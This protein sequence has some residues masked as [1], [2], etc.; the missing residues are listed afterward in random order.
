MAQY[1]TKFLE[2]S[3]NSQPS[4]WTKRWNTNSSFPVVS[5]VGTIALRSTHS[6]SD[7]AV[8][9]WNAVPSKANVEI[10]A[11]IRTTAFDWY[12]NGLYVRG[13]G[14]AGSKT[15]YYFQMFENGSGG[16]GLVIEKWVGGSW[17][18]IAGVL[19]SWSPNT[20]YWAR[21]RVSGSNLYAKIW[22][23]GSPEPGSWTM[24]ASDG[25]IGGA[26]WVGVGAYEP[27][28]T[29]YFDEVAVATD[30]DTAV[31]TPHVYTL[32]VQDAVHGHTA[33]E[34]VTSIVAKPPEVEGMI[35]GGWGGQIL[36]GAPF[37]SGPVLTSTTT[38]LEVQDTVHGHTAEEPVTSIL[39]YLEPD[40]AVQGHTADNA[41]ITQHHFLE[42]DSSSQLHTALGSLVLTENFTLVVDDAFHEHKAETT[43]AVPGGNP[44]PDGT[45]HEHTID[46]ITL[47]QKHVLSVDSA[48]Q[49]HSADAVLLS[50]AHELVVEDAM[51]AHNAALIILSQHHLLVVLGALHGQTVESVSL[52][53][54]YVLESQDALHEHSVESPF[55]FTQL[56]IVVQDALH[57]LSSDEITILIKP[58]LTPPQAI[59][60]PAKS[61]PQIDKQ[62]PRVDPDRTGTQPKARIARNV[63][64][65]PV[66]LNKR[67]GPRLRKF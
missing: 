6:G 58:K 22:P 8:L 54:K 41:A 9:S 31:I 19:Y 27:N 17:S 66:I 48:V 63:Q 12:Q 32:T 60:N 37:A 13:A 65:T 46:N 16:G 47:Q 26:G 33:E 39:T 50:Q 34:P 2:Y 30:G 1:S 62:K 24:T 55:V 35:S 36:G 57:A 44:V 18:S 45:F 29:K 7:D 38:V 11:K 59:V 15:G 3:L 20:W 21:F 25:S 28:G 53:Q 5:A 4:D 43:L 42:V 51:Q 52:R 49:G 56:R 64:R 61:R 23:H 14:S 67:G 10:L 40:D